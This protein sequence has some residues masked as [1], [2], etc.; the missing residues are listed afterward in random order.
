MD[1]TSTSSTA[2]LRCA[3][4]NP[5][6][7]LA[8]LDQSEVE[9][10]EDS[11]LIADHAGGVALAGIMG[12]LDSSVQ[13][14]TRNIFLEAA[15]FTALELAGK[16]RGFGMHTDAS[17]RFERGVDAQLPP[18]AMQRATGLLLDIVGGEAGPIIDAMAV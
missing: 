2:A 1:L 3:S 5:G 15:H 12:G 14:D 6:E 4:Q 7:K 8:L 16:A 18:I 13:S 17:H 10:R 9:C 11:L